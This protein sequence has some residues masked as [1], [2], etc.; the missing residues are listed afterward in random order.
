[1]FLITQVLSWYRNVSLRRATIRLSANN[2]FKLNKFFTLEDASVVRDIFHNR[3]YAA[4]FPFN[5]KVTILDIGAHKGYFSIFASKNT[6]N[7]SR[8][9]AFEPDKANYS[10]LV[11]NLEMN[12]INNVT[13][14][15]AGVGAKTG[16]STFFSGMDANSSLFEG[17][18]K[19]SKKNKYIKTGIQ[20]F[21]LD[22]VLKDNAIEAVDFLKMDC[23]GAEYPF[24]FNA[25]DES[26]R[27]IS[28]IALEY[29]DL[30]KQECTGFSM[31]RFLKSKGFAIVQ[32]TVD[33]ADIDVNSGKLIASRL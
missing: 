11:E 4:A 30:K 15:N 22:D 24:I 28:T 3:H 10:Q 13:A 19:I 20:V 12:G 21:S 17:Y 2:G 6:D 31:Y 25:D 16:T 23:E 7:E 32:F 9:I 29:H 1:M 27:R 33:R 26:L 8:I 18:D 5:Q 14:I